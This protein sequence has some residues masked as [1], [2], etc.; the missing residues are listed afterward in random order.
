MAMMF[1]FKKNAHLLRSCFILFL[2][3]RREK[4]ASHPKIIE[5]GHRS[6]SAFIFLLSFLLMNFSLRVKL[7][8]I[9]PYIFNI[10]FAHANGMISFK[11]FS[12]L[13]F[14]YSYILPGK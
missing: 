5:N 13:L 10:N 11:S 4:V 2:I 14:Y 9:M 1:F 6:T 3:I 12:S 7:F 8:S